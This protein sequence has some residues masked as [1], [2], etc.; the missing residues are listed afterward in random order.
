[1]E[2]KY[3]YAVVSFCADLTDSTARSMPVAI[4]MIAESNDEVIAVATGAYRE[5]DDPLASAFLKDVPNLLRVHVEDALSEHP[6]ADAEAILCAL[7]HS[8]RNSVHVSLVS[9]VLSE[10]DCGQ[11]SRNPGR[12]TDNHDSWN[13]HPR[14]GARG[15]TRGVPALFRAHAEDGD[16]IREIAETEGVTVHA[17]NWWLRCAREDIGKA[18]GRER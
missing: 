8:L 15:T 12:R 17:I 9:P 7:Q 2:L 6:D 5:H 16:T 4:L 3:R 10:N 11:D 18:A 13:P 1:M 14:D